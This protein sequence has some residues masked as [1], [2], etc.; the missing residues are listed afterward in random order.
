MAETNWVVLRE[1]MTDG[2]AEIDLERLAQAGIPAIQEG[3][4]A[5]G[6]A[7]DAD[8]EMIVLVPEE[9]LRRARDVLGL[10]AEEVSDV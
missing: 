5:T 6:D 4:A 10:D 7:S 8:A 3:P 9:A 1:Y 2:H